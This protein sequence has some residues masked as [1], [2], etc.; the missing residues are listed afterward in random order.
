M[1]SNEIENVIKGYLENPK[2]DYAIMIDGE[3]GVGKTYFI[4]H[5]LIKIIEKI[6]NDNLKKKCAYVSLYGIKSLEE[7]SKEIL[8]QYFATNTKKIKSA[9]KLIMTAS[10]ILLTT[11]EAIHIDVSKLKNLSSSIED[12]ISKI[13]INNWI[14]CFDD[15]ERC[16]LPINEILGYIN[17]LVEHNNCK[18]IVLANEKEIGKIHLNKR[19][20]NKYQVV[21]SGRKLNLEDDSNDNE[22]F[23]VEKLQEATNRLFNEDILYKVIREK[24]IGYTIKFEPKLDTVYDSIIKKYCSE[25]E[26]KKYLD[27][28]KNGILGYLEEFKCNNLRTFNFILGSFFKVFK[29]MHK[30]Y[31]DNVY[32]DKIMNDFLKYIV[33]IS[34]YYRNGG[35]I[36]KLNLT[37]EIGYI[38]LKNKPYQSIKGFKFLE[39]YCITLNFSVERFST[40]VEE[41][42]KEYLEED[43]Q[44]KKGEAYRQLWDWYNKDDDEIESLVKQLKDEIEKN[45]YSFFDYQGIIGQ[46]MVLQYW[47]HDVGSID[48]L[49]DIM[50]KNIEKSNEEVNVEKRSFSFEE[51]SELCEQYNV[52]VNKLKF[53]AMKRNH[54]IKKKEIK[55]ILESDGGI[56]QLTT[57]CQKHY[58]DF[59]I[60]NG[61]ADLLDLELLIDKMNKASVMELRQIKNIF[62]TVYS[63]A[64]INMFFKDDKDIICDFAEKVEKMQLNGINKPLARD[65]LVKSLKNIIERLSDD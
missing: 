23:N 33:F 29:E 19:L 31:N 35:S 39:E 14:I 52:Y 2:S 60:R 4:T 45:E 13:D 64:N 36:K 51:D 43:I 38:K 53:K 50:N 63:A 9:E 8:F 34:V 28:N 46:L 56:N 41:L 54:E 25:K 26:F 11:L 42:K 21:M 65:D 57:Y 15:L 55:N 62:E 5:S 16:N 61:F 20:E 24:V 40:V 58:N 27:K 48:D 22:N 3:W 17:R 18:V 6:E 59:S 1:Y 44:R 32:F 10:N 37:T 47:K 7:I 49:I 12:I 30:T